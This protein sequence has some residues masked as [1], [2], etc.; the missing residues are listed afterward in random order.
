MMTMTLTDRYIATAIPY[1]AQ[2][3]RSEIVRELRAAIADD[4]DARVRAAMNND[5]NRGNLVTWN[6]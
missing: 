6:T 3:Q 4:I 2:P 1:L 5:V